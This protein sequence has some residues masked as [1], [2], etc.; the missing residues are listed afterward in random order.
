MSLFKSFGSKKKPGSGGSSMSQ[1][2]INNRMQAQAAKA[3]DKIVEL[4]KALEK[5][6]HEKMELQRQFNDLENEQDNLENE[7]EALEEQVETLTNERDE[8]LNEASEATKDKDKAEADTKFANAMKENALSTVKE[9]EEAK[10]NLENELENTIKEMTALQKDF[11]QKSAKVANFEEKMRNQKLANAQASDTIN[12]LET[13]IREMN[14]EKERTAKMVKLA[15]EERGVMNNTD[16]ESYM[17]RIIWQQEDKIKE[18]ILDNDRMQES[19]KKEWR[20]SQLKAARRKLMTNQQLLTQTTHEI[21]C[22]TSDPTLSVANAVKNGP[23]FK[24]LMKHAV[25]ADHIQNTIEMNKATLKA[26]RIAVDNVNALSF[27]AERNDRDTIKHILNSQTVQVNALDDGGYTALQ[28]ACRRG[29]MES[30]ILLTEEYN[31]DIKAGHEYGS[32]IILAARFG[33]VHIVEYLMG[34]NAPLDAIDAE[35][36]TALMNA[37][38]NAHPM[39]V[40][41]LLRPSQNINFVDKNKMSALHVVCSVADTHVNIMKR[42]IQCLQF[43]LDRKLE[44]ELE[45]RSGNTPLNTCGIHG[46]LECGKMLLRHGANVFQKNKMKRDVA[47]SARYYKRIKFTAWINGVLRRID[48]EKRAARKLLNKKKLSLRNKK[49]GGVLPEVKGEG[50]PI[51]P[52]LS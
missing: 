34:N 42:R 30:V 1:E 10:A 29:N 48:D 22:L 40:A 6:K 13:S 3:R 4:S 5:E 33:F 45:D 21:L 50:K 11:E 8:A 16:Y 14:E 25:Q 2:Q 41:A 17:Q 23:K 43:L 47:E 39:C 46:S 12:K 52:Q 26:V 9:L 49:A 32:P 44:I 31:A 51:F 20:Q 36:R 7:K 27:A 18:L 38:Y 19:K 35:G 28:A 15:F 24:K 37:A